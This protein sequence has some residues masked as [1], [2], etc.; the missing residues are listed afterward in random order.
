MVRHSL[1]EIRR[2]HTEGEV[3]GLSGEITND[4]GGVT[5]PEGNKTFFPVCTTK[6][7]DDALIRGSKTALFNLSKQNEHRLDIVERKGLAI[8]S[9]L[10]K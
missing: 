4:I 2:V 1:I 3:Q 6:A 8:S 7:I 5:S 10:C 9:Y